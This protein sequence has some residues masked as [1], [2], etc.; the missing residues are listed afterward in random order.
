MSPKLFLHESSAG[1]IQLKGSAPASGAVAGAL[2]SNFASMHSSSPS[3]DA[4]RFGANRRGRRSAAPGAGA[5][6]ILP[7]C[8]ESKTFRCQRAIRHVQD[9]VSPFMTTACW[10]LFAELVLIAF[11]PRGIEDD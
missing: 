2:A 8:Y 10:V 7:R 11:Y 9:A 3:G 5:V 4:P 1:T 6:P